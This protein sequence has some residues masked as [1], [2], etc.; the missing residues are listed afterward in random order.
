MRTPTAYS[1]ISLSTADPF[2]SGRAEC[3]VWRQQGES[4]GLQRSAKSWHGYQAR[5][6]HANATCKN[7]RADKRG[8][9]QQTQT[10]GAKRG[11]VHNTCTVEL[12]WWLEQGSGVRT[13]WS[14]RGSGAH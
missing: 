7:Q 2:F 5:R 8:G 12:V 1:S 3:G 6:S 9:E 11:C 13:P 14:L 4:P 10:S